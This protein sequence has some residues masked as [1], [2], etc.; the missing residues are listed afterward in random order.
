MFLRDILIKTVGSLS[1]KLYVGENPGTEAAGVTILGP[2]MIATGFVIAGGAVLLATL[3]GDHQNDQIEKAIARAL[4]E[5]HENVIIEERISIMRETYKQNDA[6][7][8]LGKA[9]VDIHT[10]IFGTFIDKLINGVPPIV[11]SLKKVKE[12]SELSPA[13]QE[14]LKEPKIS[15]QQNSELLAKVNALQEASQVAEARAFQEASQAAEAKLRADFGQTNPGLIVINPDT[16]NTD[17][18]L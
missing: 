16:D 18:D 10:G 7:N 3:Q 12:V 6:I 13:M 8:K 4:K 14:L 11:D 5:G 1:Y 2:R 17:I 9:V 15:Q